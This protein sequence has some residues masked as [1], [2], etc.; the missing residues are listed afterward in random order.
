MNQDNA[1]R[2]MWQNLIN[3]LSKLPMN[4]NIAE[5]RNRIIAANR[6]E[7]I[8]PLLEEIK[9]RID[10]CLETQCKEDQYYYYLLRSYCY[11][12]MNKMDE[13][14]NASMYAID[15]FRLCGNAW[16][17][18]FGHWFLGTIYAIQRRGYLCLAEIKRAKEILETI[19][20]E[21]LIQGEYDNANHCQELV[22]QLEQ[23][24][25]VASKMGTGPLYMPGKPAPIIV[26][27]PAPF[28][29]GRLLLPWLPRYQA[30]RAGPG[31]LVWAEPTRENISFITKLEINGKIFE[32][33][34]ARGSATID[35][36]I[37]LVEHEQY[38]LAMVEGHSMNASRPT[39]ICQGDY[40]LFRSHN[41][42]QDQ[43]IV[44]ASKL[45]ASGDFAY[46]VKRYHEFE[47][48]LTSESDD[49]AQEY[50]PLKLNQ[51]HQILGIV[52]AVAKPER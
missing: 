42:P 31:G 24:R 38:G 25:Q 50:P 9:F 8:S 13:A 34:A 47:K 22:T 5:L 10:L 29:T 21:F 52:I 40:I 7:H 43:D 33:H 11:L 1:G 4:D 28:V 3:S 19:R 30:V 45:T 49:I 46:M 35:H 51:N 18:V 20:Q 44:V 14:I 26:Q 27:P 17:Q 36:N 2:I 15:G 39:H 6:Q 37:T 16:S 48:E 32:I 12:W 41:Q 23:D